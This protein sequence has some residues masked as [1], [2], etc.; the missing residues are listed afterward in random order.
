M[1]G[2]FFP[3][4]MQGSLLAYELCYGPCLL[5]SK[6]LLCAIFTA[7]SHQI[8]HQGARLP[9]G[10]LTQKSPGTSILTAVFNS[11]ETEGQRHHLFI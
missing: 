11:E 3:V 9:V 4:S 5:Q 2:A 1:E 8:S 7:F 10:H 6:C